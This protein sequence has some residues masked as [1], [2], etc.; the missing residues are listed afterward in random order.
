MKGVGWLT[1]TMSESA[2]DQLMPGELSLIS[3]EL[4]PRPVR[5]GSKTAFKKEQWSYL[6]YLFLL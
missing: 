5:V 4:Q 6:S 3:Q 2:G 1:F